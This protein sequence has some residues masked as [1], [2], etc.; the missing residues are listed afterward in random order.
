M[1]NWFFLDNI[2]IKP[3]QSL[4][5]KNG[6][7]LFLI[8][9]AVASAYPV[10]AQGSKEL[11]PGYYVVVGAYAKT[12]ANIAQNYVETLKLSGIQADYGFNASRNLYFVYL[13]YFNTLKEALR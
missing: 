6:L 3:I 10:F 4:P 2:V 1:E 7:I 8:V 9:F 11:E 13:K 5:M 12:K